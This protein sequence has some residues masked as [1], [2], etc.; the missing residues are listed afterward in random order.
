[1]AQSLVRILVH[2]TFSTKLR[3]RLIAADMRDDLNAYLAGTLKR[4]GCPAI[5]VGSVV[6]HVHI[7]C[8]LSKEV[9]I[10]KLLEE[11]KKRSSKW[12]KTKWPSRRNSYWQAGYGAFSVSESNVGKVR[13]Y[14]VGQEEHH[15]KMTFQDELRALLKRHNV[16]YDDRYL[17]D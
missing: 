13:Q 17:W 6:D 1:M 7:L 8:H 10:A 14:I 12:A 9:T 3:R 4:I 5:L 16:A 15:K 11:I 2:L